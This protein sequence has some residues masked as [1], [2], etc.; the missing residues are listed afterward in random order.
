MHVC[1]QSS[2]HTAGVTEQQYLILKEHSREVYAYK[3]QQ[4]YVRCQTQEKQTVA[5]CHF[6]TYV[7]THINTH[8]CAL[9]I[10]FVLAGER[11]LVK[12]LHHLADA[13]GGVSQ[14]GSQRHTWGRRKKGGV[15]SRETAG[16]RR[17]QRVFMNSKQ[18]RNKFSFIRHFVERKE[19]LANGPPGYESEA[20]LGSVCEKIKK[21]P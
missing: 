2:E 15:R 12:P 4:A 10:V 18:L 17:K 1:T 5:L 11:R 6:T 19:G 21:T 20:D 7:R 9:A 8:L 13:L 3:I 14:H 16:R